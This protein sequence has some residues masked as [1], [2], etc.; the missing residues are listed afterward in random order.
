MII[1]NITVT[2]IISLAAASCSPAAYE[3][4]KPKRVKDR[5][6]ITTPPESSNTERRTSSGHEPSAEIEVIVANQSV[7]QVRVGVPTLLRPTSDSLDPD[8]IDSSACANPGLV[9]AEYAVAGE[10]SPR[11]ERKEGCETLGVPYTF[12]KAG[13]I[14]IGLRVVSK[15]Q[16]DAEASMILSVIDGSTPNDHLDY[17]RISA[18]PLVQAKGSN[19][20]F[21]ASCYLGESFKVTW[22]FGDNTEGTGLTVQHAYQ[23]AKAYQVNATCI[24]DESGKT[25][26]AKLT[27]TILDDAGKLPGKVGK[28][29]P[30]SPEQS[31]HPTQQGRPGQKTSYRR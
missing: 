11:A 6:D 20:N 9:V 25:L 21:T 10:G 5:H 28:T 13:E 7:T 19:I 4:V 15:D 1:R 16:E 8:Y 17:F 12:S 23:E 18:D 27:T 24:G 3:I 31:D 30:N 2:S 29:T 26:K 22:N 14:E